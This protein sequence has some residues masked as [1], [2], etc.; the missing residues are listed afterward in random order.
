MIPH[1]VS[2]VESSSALT[3]TL[4]EALGIPHF[5]TSSKD[6]MNVSEAF[7]S[8]LNRVEPFATEICEFLPPKVVEIFQAENCHS[9]KL[10]SVEMDNA[11]KNAKISSDD[12]ANCA[13][14]RCTIVNPTAGR[15]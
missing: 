8:L 2:N 1:H 12:G 5:E 13:P 10:R 15:K 9:V 7:M 6:D 4:A 14:V 11:H 3:Q